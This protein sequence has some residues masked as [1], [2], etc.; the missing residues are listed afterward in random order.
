MSN[1]GSAPAAASPSD[2]GRLVDANA[3]LSQQVAASN[4]AIAHLAP[5]HPESIDE[6]PWFWRLAIKGY[7]QFQRDVQGVAACVPPL[8]CS[9]GI[10]NKK[11]A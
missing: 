6:L 10:V 8:S 3:L 4:A 7:L 9:S 2:V 11:Q 1:N 5:D